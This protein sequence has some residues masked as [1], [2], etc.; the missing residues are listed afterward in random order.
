VS[1]SVFVTKTT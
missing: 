1:S